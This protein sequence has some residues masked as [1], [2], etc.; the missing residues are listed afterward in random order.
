VL[1]VSDLMDRQG[2]LGLRATPRD[3]AARCA[4]D[5][6]SGGRRV[7]MRPQ[8]PGGV[9]VGST[10]VKAVVVD[11]ATDEIS[12]PTT[13][14]TRPSSPRRRSSSSSARAEI[15]ASPGDNCRVFITGS[16][17][18]NI[19]PLIGAKFVQEVNAVS[20]AVEKL[21]PEVHS[22]IEL[23]GQ[24][25]KIIVFK[26]DPETGRKK[27]I[28]SMN[29]KCAGGTGA[30][31]D[32]INAKLKIPPTSSASRATTASSCTR[33]RASAASSPRPTS[34]ACRRGH[35]ARRADGVA[36]RRDRPAEP[37][38]A[39][40]R[41]HAAAARAA[42]RRPEHLHPGMREAGG[43]TSRRCGRSAASS[44]PGRDARDAHQ[45]AR[46][47]AVLRRAR[48][49]RVRQGRGRRRRPLRGRR[50]RQLEHYIDVGAARGE[51]EGRRRRAR[52]SPPRSSTRSRRS[53]AQ[54]R[55]RR[56]FE[57]GE[58][59]RGFVGVDGGSTSTKAVLLVDGR[60]RALQGLPAVEGQPDPGHHRHVRAARAGRAQG[61]TL[62][63]LGVGTTG[64]AKDILKDVLQAD[65][66]LV[67]TV[68]HTESACTSTR[69]ARH[70]RRRRPGHQADRPQ[71][72]PRQGLQAE[73]A[74]LGRQRLLP[75]VHAEGFGVPVER[76][77]RPRLRAKAMP[78][79]GYGC[80]VFMQSDIVNFQRQGW[81]PRRSWPAWRPCCRRTSGSTSP[82]PEPGQARH[83]LRAAGRH[84]AQPGGREGGGR[85]HPVEL[86]RADVE[87]EIIVHEHCGESGAIGAPSRRCAS[88]RTAR[89]RRSS[90][91]RPCERKITYRT[92]RNE[93]TRCNFCKNNC[94]RTFID[95]KMGGRASRRTVAAAAKPAAAAESHAVQ[96]A[97]RPRKPPKF[98]SK[99]RPTTS[100]G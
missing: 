51:E 35:A 38:G 55:S 16:G 42:A 75:A 87:P 2:R 53:T 43:T 72:R 57:P 40:A 6:I 59:V 1:H 52:A 97:S 21:H 60:R 83:A 36:L 86:P 8:L 54:V 71:G 47:R 25:A 94:L 3:D 39:D 31:I 14:G 17:G 78:I 66:A 70:R 81:A 62:E 19:A 84:A 69:T 26:E 45:D 77:R 7:E 79:F 50:A 41:A 30:V 92:T 98:V 22:V 5:L 29:D 34:T 24:D 76:V 13:S 58:V 4:S 89:R 10:T 11:A 100:S 90:A 48:R 46:Q 91:S 96:G 37:V 61:A 64:Y 99:Q 65:A 67:E 33:W 95:V 18:S 32:K 56:R 28:P 23:G 15:S 73:H 9:D 20:L 82:D 68:A 63:V 85:L 49:G 88:G 12:G 80:A 93:A 27:K 44:C 74:V